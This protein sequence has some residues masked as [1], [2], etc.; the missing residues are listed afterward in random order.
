MNE[1]TPVQW[2]QFV[3]NNCNLL[4]SGKIQD[5]TEVNELSDAYDGFSESEKHTIH[6]LL[7]QQL[8]SRD[9]VLILSYLIKILIKNDFQIDVAELIDK[10]NYDFA[11][12]IMLEV[13]LN[14]LPYYEQCKIHRKNVEYIQHELNMNFLYQPVSHRKH[15]R[16]VLITEQLLNLYHAPTRMT[17][18]IAYVLQ[19]YFGYEVEIF[20]CA[21]NKE[22]PVYLWI[23]TV[24]YNSAKYGYMKMEY[25]DMML[26]VYQYPLEECGINEYREMIS[27][28]YEFNPLFVLETGVCNPVAD[29]LHSFTTVANLNTVTEAPV[30]V[31][32]IF[33][34]LTKLN[35]EK[36]KFYE[37]QLL[38]YQRQIFMEQ[39]FPA[40]FD[41]ADRI[42]TREEFNLPKN[43]FLIVI[44]GNRLDQEITEEF[45][46]VIVELLGQNSWIDFVIAGDV[47]LLPKSFEKNIF[48][49]RIHYL[50]FCRN[51]AGLYSIMDLYLNPKR[52]G[53][54]WS[55]AIALQ[56]G[57]PIITLP[58]CDV[59]Y[60]A[61]KDFIVQNYEEMRD[62]ALRYAND[63]DF[64]E[65]KKQIV[66]EF[67]KK[68][69]ED[70]VVDFIDR[71]L[72]K[73]QEELLK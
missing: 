36:E 69:S 71:M 43:R 9:A 14:Q 27:N 55:S 41:K 53:G 5:M 17:Y 61:S 63:K 66:L 4:F 47:E 72:E 58:E 44:V 48:K 2:L 7:V 24:K 19:R 10:G 30:S 33:I 34:R 15:D 52:L 60:N 39:K 3:I 8:E 22:I 25:K 20:S 46:E 38:E 45:R 35:D 67:A 64:Y 21:S 73:I 56:E 13:Q 57:V 54:G 50:G 16:I 6:Q 68:N 51:L 1:Y 59:A 40:I 37:E 29:I 70:K 18:E 31:A 65:N 28:I 23:R 32:D 49:N 42:Y 62:M 12:R 26:N 11:I